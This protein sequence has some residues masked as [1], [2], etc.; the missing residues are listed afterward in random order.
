MPE[1]PRAR[2]VPDREPVAIIGMGCR[3][4]GASG[5]EAFWQVL[6]DARDTVGEYLPGRFPFIDSVYAGTSPAG[7]VATRAGGFLPGLDGFDAEFFGISPREAA[8]LDP[9]LRLLFEVSWEALEDAGLPREQ[10]AGSATGVFMA[11]WNSDYELALRDGPPEL[12]FHSTLGTGRYSA[13]GRLSY[14]LD[15]RGPSM[16]LDTACSSSLVA[17]HLACR[18][19][20]SGECEMAL[21]G[22][23]N[24]ILRPEISLIY[25]RAGMLSPDGLSKF[26]DASANGYV[27]SEGAG[28][29]VLKPLSKALAACDRIE[30]LIRGGAVNNDGQSSGL[31]VSPS[32]EAQSDLLRLALADAGIG[33]GSVDYIEAHGTGTPVGDPVELEAIGRVMAETRGRHSPC[34]V[35]SVKTNIGHVESA[36][37][38]AGVMKAAM[39]LRHG[40]IPANL[41]FHT[42]NPR[43]PWEELPIEIPVEPVTWPDCGARASP[44]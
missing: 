42:P 10:L 19:L 27:R 4:P 39:S 9:Q 1:C 7:R 5:P 16:T 22:G 21:A 25:S 44:A 28:V 26:G 31:L 17:I 38:V 13:S 2:A 23:A 12:D 15:L 14:F 20:W 11:L 34:R 6:R 18:S 41:H 24:A 35:G 29:L 33:P 40:V 36:A 43:V 3:F 30:A 8:F 32:R 37:G